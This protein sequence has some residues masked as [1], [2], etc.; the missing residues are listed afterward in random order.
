MSRI[1][2]SALLSCVALAASTACARVTPM[3]EPWEDAATDV[4]RPGTGGAGAGSA[5]ARGGTGGTSKPT[6][7]AG[8]SGAGIFVTDAAVGDGSICGLV[9]STLEKQPPDVLIVLDRSASMTGQVIP[10]GFDVGMFIACLVLNNCP[11]TMSKWDAMTGAL[12]S[13]LATSATAVNFGLKLFP[14]DANCGV[15][16]GVAVPIASDNARPISDVLAKTKPGGNT[17][18]T[19][20]LASAGRFLSTL[21]RPNP[22]FVLLATDGEPTCLGGGLGG[23]AA[24]ATAAIKDLAAAGIPVYVIGIATEGIADATL[25]SMAMAGGRPRSA[26]PPYYPV[27]TAADLSA[28]LSAIGGQIA[29]CSFTVQRPDPPADPHN[30]AVKANGMKV[31]K[32]E[33]DGWRYGAD[34]GSIELTGSW[35]A[36]IKS[37]AITDLEAI[38]ACAEA[39]IP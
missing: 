26:N 22:R 3:Q 23:D 25:S 31:P 38:F 4:P 17:P 16:E 18:T 24:A 34:M 30:V 27:Q 5:S 21:G 11:A 13:S 29:S 10:P 20:A 28:T 2:A 39:I 9:H 36:Q 15:T 12:E 37:G 1:V 6:G 33:T 7:G 35:C 8:G 14:D 19:A 32:S